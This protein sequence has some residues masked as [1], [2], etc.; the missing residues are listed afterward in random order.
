MT[1]RT[2]EGL[3]TCLKVD[4]FPGVIVVRVVVMKK[5]WLGVVMMAVVKLGWVVFVRMVGNGSLWTFG[6]NSG[7]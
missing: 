2:L 7:Q 4:M 5:C 3:S 1:S 6:G